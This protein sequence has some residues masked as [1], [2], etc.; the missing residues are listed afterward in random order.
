MAQPST[1]AALTPAPVVQLTG[2]T[3]IHAGEF[4]TCATLPG[5]AARCWGSNNTYQLGDGTPTAS[6]VPVTLQ[7]ISIIGP[8]PA[9]GIQ[10]M[11]A[12]GFH[13][14]SL[15]RQS[16][17]DLGLCWGTNLSGQLGNTS[18]VAPELTVTVGGIDRVRQ[19]AVGRA[20]SCAIAGVG[21]ASCWGD[22]S[23]GQLG[24]GSTSP[25]GTVNATPAEVVGLGPI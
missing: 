14:C 13:N 22:N 15:V 20:S 19:I 21:A 7:F 9:T 17:S 10:S 3:S 1:P 24:R 2:A 23:D 18:L 6:S 11:S 25:F 12:G 8:A 5:G 16:L 4:H